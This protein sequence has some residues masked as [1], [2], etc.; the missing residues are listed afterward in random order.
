MSST[1]DHFLQFSIIDILQ[2][3][4]NKREIKYAREFR[5]FNK[6][7]FGEEPGMVFLAKLMCLTG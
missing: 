5:H 3:S 4:G 1:S 6:N 2:K 7:E